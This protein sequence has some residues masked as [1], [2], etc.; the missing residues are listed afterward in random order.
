VVAEFLGGRIQTRSGDPAGVA[1]ADETLLVGPVGEVAGPALDGRRQREVAG[2]PRQILPRVD[3]AG[4]QAELA[5][6]RVVGG[7]QFGLAGLRHRRHFVDGPRERFRAAGRVDSGGGEPLQRAPA[8]QVG[9]LCG[10]EEDT[11]PV[12]DVVGEIERADDASDLREAVHLIALGLRGDSGAVVLAAH[13]RE[14]AALAALQP[15]RTADLRREAAVVARPGERRTGPFG[16]GIVVREGPPLGPAV[17]GVLGDDQPTPGT[18][19]LVV[20]TPESPLTLGAGR[21]IDGDT[22]YSRRFVEN[23]LKKKSSCPGYNRVRCARSNRLS[24]GSSRGRAKRVGATYQ[25]LNT[26]IE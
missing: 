1:A 3:G 23:I 11:G 14:P 15:R 24:V 4:R 8:E 10:L 20:G 21:R 9:R 26:G 25:G 19:G 16:I 5:V 2:E 12:A 13:P 22:H 7:F 17:E 6:E 18:D